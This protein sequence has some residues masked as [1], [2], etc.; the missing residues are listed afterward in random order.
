MFEK[1]QD[2]ICEWVLAHIEKPLRHYEPFSLSDP[3]TLRATLEPGDVLLVE[4]NQRISAIIKYL[5]QSTWSHMA[6]YVG[7]AMG[8]AAGGGEPP[9]LIEAGARDGVVAVP[10]SKYA[11]FNTRICRPVG[12]SDKDRQ[13]VVDFMIEALGLA[14][15]TRNIT[16]LMRYLFPLPPVPVRLR[17]R[18]L[19]LGSGD[20]TRAIC[21]SLIAQAFQSVRYP[22]LPHIIA[23][24]ADLP[25]GCEYTVRE[26]LHI[27]H[28][29]LFTPRDFDVSPYFR[30][31]K[32]TLAG[33]FDY[34]ALVWEGEA[35]AAAPVPSGS[36]G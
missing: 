19:A 18:M 11:S 33:G 5:T 8:P 15:D 14:Y 26:I 36:A 9:S 10:L 24:Q 32:P 13:K 31:I 3:E 27:R 23:E 6:F 20:P 2:K 1:V 25:C 12:L 16:D 21:S 4:G 34:K 28:H 30:V 7:D 22:I 35:T 17:R 29:S